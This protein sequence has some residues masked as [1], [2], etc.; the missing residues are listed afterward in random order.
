MQEAVRDGRDCWQ[1]MRVQRLLTTAE[2]ALLKSAEAADNLPWA[3]AAIGDR[4]EQRQQF[5]W[6]F[7]GEFL[8]PVVTILLSLFV[9]A[10]A[11]ACFLPLVRMISAYS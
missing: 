1:E 8:H 2:A 7:A 3:L 5:R 6:L 10:F 11:V 9:G 4:C